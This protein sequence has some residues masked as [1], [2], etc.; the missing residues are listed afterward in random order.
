MKRMA[1]IVWPAIELRTNGA[2]LQ[3]L[4]TESQLQFAADLESEWMEQPE[5]ESPQ[6]V[7]SSVPCQF[8]GSKKRGH[9]RDLSINWTVPNTFLIRSGALCLGHDVRRPSEDLSWSRRSAGALD[10]K[11]LPARSSMPLARCLNHSV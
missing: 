11:W 5:S 2:E 3:L 1:C 9:N 10:L 6:P 8:L 4:W 7:D